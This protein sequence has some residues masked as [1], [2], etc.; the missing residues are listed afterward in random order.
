MSDKIT[1]TVPLGFAPEDVVEELRR[2]EAEQAEANKRIESRKELR[3]KFKRVEDLA[4]ELH[5]ASVD[6]H[7]T[8]LDERPQNSGQ[9]GELLNA[10]CKTDATAQAVANKFRGLYY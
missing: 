9:T 7:S 5:Q 10:A 8:L 3:A 4:R 1:I 6:L 2:R